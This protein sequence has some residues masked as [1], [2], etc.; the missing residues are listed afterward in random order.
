M[1]E[2]WPAVM[3]IYSVASDLKVVLV[4]DFL[5]EEIIREAPNKETSRLL[6]LLKK[7]PDDE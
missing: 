5:L 7:T 3:G 4:K 6:V 2:P 1:C